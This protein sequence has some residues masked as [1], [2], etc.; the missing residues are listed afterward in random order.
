[1][2]LLISQE[3]Q[4]CNFLR[5]VLHASALDGWQRQ[6]NGLQFHSVKN[7]ERTLS[8]LRYNDHFMVLE[9]K[10]LINNFFHNIAQ[11]K[12]YSLL[13]LVFPLLSRYLIA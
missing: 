5:V 7:S 1:M 6:R 4:D 3:P 11:I 12:L 13:S 9:M 2:V 8:D 10:L